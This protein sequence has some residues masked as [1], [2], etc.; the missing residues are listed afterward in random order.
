MR[1]TT[2]NTE[3]AQRQ[4]VAANKHPLQALL[5]EDKVVLLQTSH[6][7]R[8]GLLLMT[9]CTLTLLQHL[10]LVCMPE[11]VIDLALWRVKRSGDA[12]TRA[13]PPQNSAV[14]YPVDDDSSCTFHNR[15]Q[16]AQELSCR[17]VTTFSKDRF[18]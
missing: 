13:K 4:E 10:V 3:S 6:C 7:E 1:T 9:H 18:L 11:R 17:L 14:D 8:A 15:F 16:K 5:L 2:V 12:E